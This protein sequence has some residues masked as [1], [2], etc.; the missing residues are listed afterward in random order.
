M[1]DEI[2]VQ[3]GLSFVKGENDDAWDLIQAT[4]DMAGTKFIKNTQTVGFGAH[5]LLEL[6]DIGTPGW[7]MGK[8]LDSTN[9][10]EVGHDVAAAFEADVKVPAKTASYNGI[11]LFFCAQGAPY[12]QADTGAVDF[13]YLLIEA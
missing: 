3:M 11:C 9:F 5:E 13:K 2:T 6:G 7:L 10:M 12:V 1:A 8:N 4:F